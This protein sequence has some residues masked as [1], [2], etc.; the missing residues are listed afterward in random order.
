M[1]L[2]EHRCAFKTINYSSYNNIIKTLDKIHKFMPSWMQCICQYSFNNYNT[3]PLTG[4]VL[5]IS[6]KINYGDDIFIDEAFFINSLNIFGY[7]KS[8]FHIYSSLGVG[9]PKFIDL[10]QNGDFNK[11]ILSYKDIPIYQNEQKLNDLK[12]KLGDFWFNK[13]IECKIT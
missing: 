12:A 10:F 13:E 9:Y 7:E 5:I 11:F 8:N 2:D 1:F 4:S 3:F 6:D